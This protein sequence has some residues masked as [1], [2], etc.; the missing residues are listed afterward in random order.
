MLIHYIFHINLLKL[1]T[2]DPLP[3]QQIIPPL[4]IEVDREQEWGVSEVLDVRMFRRW[5]QYL[6]QWTSYHA[7]SWEPAESVNRLH[8][9]NLFHKRYPDKPGSLPK[10]DLE[11]LQP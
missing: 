7:P 10:S 2:N 6:I 9:N 3:G 8:A 5:L 1:A 11:G 4:P